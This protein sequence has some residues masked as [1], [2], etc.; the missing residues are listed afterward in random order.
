VLIGVLAL[1]IVVAAQPFRPQISETFEGE[2]Y[3]HIV[4][5]NETIWG[6]GHWAVDQPKGHAIQFWE[7]H[8]EHAHHSVH[9]LSRY[10]LGFDY[11]IS[12]QHHPTPHRVCHKHAVTPPMRHSWEW[13]KDAHYHGKHVFDGTTYDVWGHRHHEFDLEVAVGEHNA[14]RPYYF[15]HRT[16][17]RHSRIHFIDFETFPANDTWFTVPDIC[18]NATEA[19]LDEQ[20]AVD[21]DD[22]EVVEH[23]G[24]APTCGMLVADMAKRIAAE[25]N[26]FTASSM[27]AMATSKAGVKASGSLA[28]LKS[29]GTRC[30]GGPMIGDVFFDGVPAT[31][32]AVML[33]ANS[34][35]ECSSDLAVGC[36]IVEQRD[37]TGGCRRFC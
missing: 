5:P 14:N 31:S 18:K 12:F 17:T 30:A 29:T 4:T 11:A 15:I 2:G 20:V 3:N 36:R 35:A 22:T 27:I 28:D 24:G 1:A 33:S 19:E 13:V 10:D 6:I 16:P 34:F 23:R 21:G 37:F 9:L 25:G 26:G 7:F 32:A 8:H